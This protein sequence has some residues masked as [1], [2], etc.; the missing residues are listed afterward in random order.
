LAFLGF[1]KGDIDYKTF[2]LKRGDNVEKDRVTSLN[3][4]GFSKVN[5]EKDLEVTGNLSI[6]ELTVD[7]II[8]KNLD[9]GIAIKLKFNEEEKKIIFD[10]YQGQTYKDYNGAID[11]AKVLTGIHVGCFFIGQDDIY[12]QK[13]NMYYGLINYFEKAFTGA[14]RPAWVNK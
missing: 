1:E 6:N 11:N 7:S 13:G 12:Y 2:V 3:I 14:N 9:T 4:K 10:T 5:I 8:P